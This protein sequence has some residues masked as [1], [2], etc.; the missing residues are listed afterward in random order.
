VE[1]GL[2][3]PPPVAT[4]R[5]A[6]S[7]RESFFGSPRRGQLTPLWVVL[8]AVFWAMV[9]LAMTGVWKASQEL[10]LATWW[11]GP[12]SD[13]NPI[14]VRTLPFYAPTA[15]VIVTLCNLRWL[16]FAGLFASAI[17]LVIGALDLS[18]VRRL[19]LVELA[20]GGAAAVF[21]LASITAMY[22]SPADGRPAASDAAP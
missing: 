20:I 19:G 16:P 21:S 6:A 8:T 2:P 15:M 1:T 10:G 5:A 11:L 22:R 3:L 12:F 18:E 14:F 9:F 17:T 13:P 7:T 4:D